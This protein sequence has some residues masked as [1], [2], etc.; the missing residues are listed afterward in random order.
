M[1][2]TH[3]GMGL[4]RNRGEL[5]FIQPGD[6]MP[7]LGP[8]TPILCNVK[9]EP[10]QDIFQALSEMSGLTDEELRLVRAGEP[11]TVDLGT[12][13]RAFLHPFLF[14][15]GRRPAETARDD[16]TEWL[17]PTILLDGESVPEFWQAY[18]H[19]RPTV[20]TIRQD[21]KHGSTTL[22]VRALEVLRDEAA[23]QRSGHRSDFFD[24][25][26]LALALRETHPAMTALRN[27]IARAIA[28]GRRND[29][30]RAVEQAAHAG[31][32]RALSA[33][34][35]TARRAAAAI[36]GKRVA[37]LSRSGTVLQALQ[38]SAPE[39]VLVAESRPGREGVSVAEQLSEM[40]PVTLCSDA[41][42]ASQLSSWDADCLLVGADSI[43]ADGRV[44]NKVGTRAAA[45]AAS[46]DAVAVFVATASDK[47]SPDTGAELEPRDD[48]ELYDGD[49]PLSIVN[50][51]FD[52]TPADCID[53]VLTERGRLDARTIGEIADEHDRLTD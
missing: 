53:G 36:E 37:T 8:L 10:R 30:P 13:G 5:L 35:E 11:V 24:I 42:F 38:D 3:L 29:G 19:V 32:E 4:L 34:T 41:G 2:E 39:A 20:E 1:G 33:D 45:V 14:D 25:D 40:V 22:S 43:L 18:D 27:R 23:V 28:Q 49:S 16:S 17:P 48:A 52:I 9:T 46:Y 15:S 44:V 26:S 47:I 6:E 51:T 21:R 31:I 7:E 12:N 50:N